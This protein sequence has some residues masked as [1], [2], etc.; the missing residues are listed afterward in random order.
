MSKVKRFYLVISVIYGAVVLFIFA[1]EALAFTYLLSEKATLAEKKYYSEKLTEKQ[2]IL[3]NLDSRYNEVKEDENIIYETLP[4]D[5]ETSKLLSDLNTIAS[6]SKLKFSGV[7][8]EIDPTK[9]S[10]KSQSDLSL[11]QTTKGKLAYELPLE[12]TVEGSYSNFLSFV[13]RVENYQ[14]L[15]NIESI[16]IGQVVEEGIA[17]NVQAE[18][19]LVA[20]LKK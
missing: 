4:E 14:R 2:D 17:D 1:A 20:Y 10:A 18:I 15:L 3:E 13:Q 5:K 9:S 12:V 7:Q 11:L 8:V 6:E 19:S 16:E